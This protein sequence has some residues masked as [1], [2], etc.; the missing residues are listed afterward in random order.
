[1]LSKILIGALTFCLL[2]VM[3]FYV[4]STTSKSTSVQASSSP[5]SPTIT[6]TADNTSPIKTAVQQPDNALPVPAHQQMLNHAQIGTTEIYT[7]VAIHK[8]KEVHQL[9]HPAKVE[10]YTPE[11]SEEDLLMVLAAESEEEKPR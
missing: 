8:L 5:I 10:R 6:I 2:V 9:T 3:G 4:N 11:D 7:H 1:M